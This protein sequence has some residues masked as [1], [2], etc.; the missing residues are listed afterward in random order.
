MA[1]YPEAAYKTLVDV[2]STESA[3]K[4]VRPKDPDASYLVRNWTSFSEMSG[5][6]IVEQ[7]VHNLDVANWFIGH[8]PQSAVGFGGRARRI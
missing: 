5:D 1:L 4:R 2:P 3:L 6:H 8:P 7:H